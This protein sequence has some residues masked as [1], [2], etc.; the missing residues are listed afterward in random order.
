M[1][2]ELNPGYRIR[3]RKGCLVT[4]GKRLG[5]G[6]QGNVY[7]VD[8]N[9]ETKVL[10]WYKH[11]ALGKD[12]KIKKKFYDNLLNNVQNGSPS[13]EFV[14]PEDI[15]EWDGG[16]FGYVMELVPDDYYEISE[17]I[18][19]NVRMKSYKTI[20]DAALKIISAFRILHNNGY[21]YQ[22]MNDGNFFINPNTGKV[23]ICDN[24]NVTQNSE[25]T[26]ILGKPRY[27]AP[28]I[29]T[30][31]NMPDNRSDL[32]SMSI[33]LFMLFCMN[34]P[35]EGKRSLIPAMTPEYQQKLYGTEP[36][37]IMDP[38][39]KSNGPDKRLHKNP[40]K[41]W[42]CLP[43]Y[44]QELFL[45][46]FSQKAMHTPSVRPK[47]LEWIKCLVRF[48]S[49]IVACSCGNDVFTKDGVSSKCD[50]CRKRIQIPFR[51][52]FPEYSVPAVDGS[53][54]YRCQVGICNADE[55]LDPVA[56]VLAKKSDPN[57][58]GLKNMSACSWDAITSK[59]TTRK[60]APDEVIP[61]KDGISLNV[62]ANAGDLPT[63]VKIKAN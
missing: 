43:D 34:H 26:G 54:I 33:I 28:E 47:E 44:M 37:F 23:L 32:F 48:R 7:M 41:V 19:C 55:A 16:T 59:G 24:D 50:G 11:S 52:E 45:K 58:L 63:T 36:L 14:W 30:R 21:C 27:M 10:K 13:P 29:V 61:L 1:A 53:R 40:L 60:A 5:G 56:R 2:D 12:E 46:A 9:G 4:V 8:Y 6:G 20:I 35:L 42:P 17:Y 57:A 22:D 25:T 39:D 15:T 62:K 18:L 51:L 31:K 38:H 3:T 49:E